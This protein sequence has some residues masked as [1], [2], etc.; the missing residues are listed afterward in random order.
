M[1]MTLISADRQSKRNSAEHEH[2]EQRAED[3]RLGEVVDRLLDEA[4]RAGRSWCRSRMPGRPGSHVV[5]GLLD[6]LA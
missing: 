1:V 6:A 4:R 5:D 3:E 2:D